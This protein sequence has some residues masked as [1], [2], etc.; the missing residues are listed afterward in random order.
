[1]AKSKKSVFF[2]SL[3]C[4]TILLLATV[5]GCA[6][7]GGSSAGGNEII[8]IASVSPLSGSESAL[9]VSMMQGVQLAVEQHAADFA[10]YHIQIQFV[11]EDDQAD[12]K[13]GVSIAQKLV[14]DPDV[15]A[16]AGHLNSG[17]TIPS[18]DVYHSAN[19]AMYTPIATNPQITEMGYQ[20]VGRVCGRDDTQGISAAVFAFNNLKAKTYFVVQDQTAYGQGI[21]DQFKKQ[22]DAEGMTSLGYEGIT[23][24]DV[25]FSAVCDKIVKA[26]PDV[27]YFGGV[28]AEGGLLLKQLRQKGYNGQVIECDGVDSPEYVN[29]AGQYVVGTYYTTMAANLGGTP[30]GQAYIAAYTAKFGK[31]PDSYATYGYDDGLAIMAGLLQAVKDSGGKVPTRAQVVTD[32]RNVQLQGVTSF[33]VFDANGDNKNAKSYVMEFKTATYPGTVVSTLTK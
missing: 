12:P 32:M 3:V 13:M 11:P 33:I 21:A 31:A 19:L 25:D 15:L 7:K 20:N 6:S 26:N 23:Q 2:V 27:V 9:G 30:Q 18:E 22:C 29:I 8:K 14:S 16:V 4:V 5:A 28:Y 1:M 10:P 17:V 24:G